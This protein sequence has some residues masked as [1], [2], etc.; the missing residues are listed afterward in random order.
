MDGE[1]TY[2]I[3]NIAEYII[4]VYASTYIWKRKFPEGIFIRISSFA[5][6][7]IISKYY[8]EKKNFPHIF[9]SE[10]NNNLIKAYGF[11]LF[12]QVFSDSLFLDN[13][14]IIIDDIIS[15]SGSYISNFAFDE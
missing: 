14:D 13:R 6:S 15:V 12:F 3:R 4:S 1:A 2:I 11:S 8:L 9:A 5:V 7:Q 10:R